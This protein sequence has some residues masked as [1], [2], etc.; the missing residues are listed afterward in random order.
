MSVGFASM[1]DSSPDGP[2]DSAE[3]EEAYGEDGVV[4]CSLLGPS[5]STS[6]VRI[7]DGDGHR[8]RHTGY[9]KEGDLRPCFLTHGPGRQAVPW[10]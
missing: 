8:Q 10:R 1:Q 5:M 9:A 6:P 4:D 2:H 7:E 3:S